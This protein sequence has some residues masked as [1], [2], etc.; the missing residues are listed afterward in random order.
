MKNHHYPSV[1]FSVA[2][3]ITIVSAIHIYVNGTE[4]EAVRLLIRWTA[5]ISAL[6]FV[7]AFG[8]ASTQY[9]LKDGFSALLL[10]YR[11]HIG[12]AFGTFHTF[13]L[14]FLIWLQK[15][16]HP[17]FTLAKTTSLLG[18]GFA[19]LRLACCGAW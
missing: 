2:F 17:V 3:L 6:L 12:L 4:E 11:P 10:R 8:A 13:H 18:G 16:I 14:F 1:I 19:Y 9:F 15:S 5:R 7:L